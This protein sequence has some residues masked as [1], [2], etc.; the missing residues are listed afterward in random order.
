MERG[1]IPE[2]NKPRPR[3]TAGLRSYSTFEQQHGLDS[4]VGG[5]RLKIDPTPGEAAESK[6]R[7]KQGMCEL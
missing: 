7:G 5:V 1:E 3:R 6:Q 2:P 4:A